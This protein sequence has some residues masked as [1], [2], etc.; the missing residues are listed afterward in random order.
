MRKVL[1]FGF[2]LFVVSHVLAGNDW[3]ERQE[4]SFWHGGEFPGATGSVAYAN[5]E[6]SL[7][8][9]FSKGGHYVAANLR[10]ANPVEAESLRMELNYEDTTTV[11]LRLMD[12][13]GQT[14]QRGFRGSPDGWEVL[15]CDISPK[16]WG[17]HWGGANDGIMHRPFRQ[18]SILAE[19]LTKDRPGGAVGILRVRNI[20]FDKE[21]LSPLYPESTFDSAAYSN[22]FACAQTACA[23][24][25]TLVPQLESRGIGAKS[26]ATLSVLENF[27]PW[28]QEDVAR[29]FTNRAMREVWEMARIAS[30]GVDR[31]KRIIAGHEKDFPVP[32][33]RTSPIQ[34][35]HAQII[36]D[37]EWPDGRRDRGPVFLTG[38]GHFGSVRR[39]LAKLPPLGCNILQMEI[40]P[41]SFLPNESAVVTNAI[42]SFTEAATRAAKENVGIILLLSPHY[43]P[44]WAKQKWPYLNDCGDKHG[45]LKYCVYDTNARTVIER[46][47]R[48]IIPLV[49]GNPALHSICLS[50]EPETHTYGNCRV[51]RKKWPEWLAARHHTIE[52]FNAR[53]N[54]GYA[55]FADV[56]MPASCNGNTPSF[57][58]MEF[59]RFNREQFA[60]WHRW[61][62]DVIHEIAP[63]IP[64]HSKIMITTYFSGSNATFYSVDPESFSALSQYSGND[65]YDFYIP[66]GFRW[67]HDWWRTEAG[68]DF[69]RTVADIPILNSENH[70]QP[71]RSKG[72]LPG[73]HTYSVLWQ[74]ALHGQ[75]A[76]TLWCW[77]RAYDDGKSDFNGLMLERPEAMEAWAH[78]SLDLARLA[79]D[80]APLQNLPP[81]ILIWHSTKAVL[82]GES[83]SFGRC[84]RVASFLGQPLGIVS[85]E[86]LERFGKGG[87][88]S[89]PFDSARVL[90]IPEQTTLTT[91]IRTGLDRFQSLGGIVSSVNDTS[92]H[93]LFQKITE[94]SSAW[95]LPDYPRAKQ[96]QSDSPVFGVETRG[97]RKDGVAT[98]SLCNHTRT[99]QN[100]RLERAGVNLI[101]G[102]PVPARFEL[103]SLTP[104]LI[105]Y[106]GNF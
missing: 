32:R 85:D 91:E 65:A 28:I 84:Y 4:L 24:L 89:R 20:R 23:E 59:V 63:E 60:D 42:R 37:R 11:T 69:Q 73:C 17:G 40:G 102:E 15:E 21:S 50:N 104:M 48:A 92:E 82:A 44:Q 53:A 56:P 1:L 12:S 99:P 45:F 86:M 87:G 83:A 8:Y 75:A 106:E 14:F 29:G 7:R 2:I 46:F 97:Y 30:N 13:T 76:T 96:P 31:A 10:F 95:K 67:S 3:I 19:N 34:I 70:I 103:P 58:L 93:I 26:R 64:V 101:T 62:A 41:N 27:F 49:R 79:E 74:N 33:Y 43:F 47:L 61:M 80:F 51:L 94:A 90:L 55:S 18:L 9:D 16:T 5:G 81:S 38:F 77:E 54:T 35:S 25:R 98:L 52:A 36:A 68:Y 66:S 105:R 22:F 39:D 78:C 71:D 6:L 100:V 88:I 57:A 72:Y